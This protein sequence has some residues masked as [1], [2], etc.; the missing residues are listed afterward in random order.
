M[1]QLIYLLYFQFVLAYLSSK[2]L[3]TSRFTTKRFCVANPIASNDSLD[4]RCQNRR[5]EFAI[6]PIKNGRGC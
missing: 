6:K 1:L 2:E 4:G 3:D 5:V